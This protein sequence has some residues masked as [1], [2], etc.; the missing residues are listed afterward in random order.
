M[1]ADDST[2]IIRDYDTCRAD[3]VDG[4]VVRELELRWSDRIWG[5]DVCR[6]PPWPEGF[7]LCGLVRQDPAA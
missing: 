2:A 1:L 3:D 4:R 7:C 5:C 6:Q